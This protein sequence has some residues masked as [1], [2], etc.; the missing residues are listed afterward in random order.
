MSENCTENR[1]KYARFSDRSLAGTAVRLTPL[2]PLFGENASGCLIDLS[3][4]GMGIIIPDLIPK[5]V[6]LRMS[7]TLPDGFI[8]E[9]AVKVR[10][11]VKQGE[12]HDYLHGVEF[13][14]PSPEMIERIEL[15]ARDVLACN[16]RTKQQM[17]EIC[18]ASC[19]LGQMCKR[20][21][22]VELNVRPAIQEL[23]TEL[24]KQIDWE[25]FDAKFEEIMRQAA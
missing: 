18:V 23:T 4:G 10:R 7:M 3:A 21:Q 24:G 5:N 12:G 1:R 13:L 2:P 14:S 22:R 6:F 15:M 20:P 17:K 8:L 19:A 25:S 11:I 16:D 9:S